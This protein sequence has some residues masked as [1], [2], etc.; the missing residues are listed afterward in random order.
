[1]IYTIVI[2]ADDPLPSVKFDDALKTTELLSILY[3]AALFG[4]GKDTVNEFLPFVIAIKRISS[5]GIHY[6]SIERIT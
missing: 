1:M 4:V 3:D 2:V 6:L 5:N